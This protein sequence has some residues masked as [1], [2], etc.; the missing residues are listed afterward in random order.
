MG[1]EPIAVTQPGESGV[2]MVQ[3]MTGPYQ[4][5]PKIQHPFLC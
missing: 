2:F 4:D 1:L 3:K 5:V